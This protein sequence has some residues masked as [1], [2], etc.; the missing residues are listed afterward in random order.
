MDFI[1]ESV[2]INTL[3]MINCQQKNK[4]SES[5][6]VGICIILKELSL[7]IYNVSKFKQW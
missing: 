7:E 2:C 1:C 5:F 4:F 3:F 6:E